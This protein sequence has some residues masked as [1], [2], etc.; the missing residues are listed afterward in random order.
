MNITEYLSNL[1][2]LFRANVTP[3]VWGIHGIGK[4]A[5][6]QQYADSGGHLLFNMRLGN[7]NDAGDLLGL[8]DFQ[9]DQYNANKKVATSFIKMDWLND[10]IN[11]ANSNPDKYAIIHLDEVNRA[12]KDLINPIFQIAIDRRLHTTVFPPNVRVIASANPP[13]S[14]NDVTYWV[15]DFTESALLDRFCHLKLSP[16]TV[17]WVAYA[18]ARNLNP[19]W[20][21][22]IADQP[23]LLHA[24]KVDFDIDAYCKPSNRSHE[25]AA[26]LHALGAPAELLV[27]CVGST[28]AQ[29]FFVFDRD[30]KDKQ[31][32]ADQVLNQVDTVLPQVRKKVKE[33]RLADLQLTL[34]EIY[35]ATE[36]DISETLPIFSM[37]VGENLVRF[38][39]ELPLDMQWAAGRQ[40]AIQNRI[41]IVISD[42]P[43]DD[44]RDMPI[45]RKWVDSLIEALESGK[46]DRSMME[47]QKT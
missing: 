47:D 40:L 33:G 18:K 28:V 30:N 21:E 11:F 44:D 22:F 39:Q 29:A 6:P 1:D 37:K 15:N 23:H 42:L 3:L 25:S 20:I 27:G 26:K 34:A 14:S 10:L 17:E 45:Q 46:I 13:I 4:S 43:E 7:M 32:T 19:A 31:I 41:S 9:V 36:G 8:P 24:T 5:V 35:K 16:T 2:F 12:R 38:L